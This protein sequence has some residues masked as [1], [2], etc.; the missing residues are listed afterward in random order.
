MII[1]RLEPLWTEIEEGLGV[2]AGNE[3]AWRVL[4]GEEAR[5]LS[6]GWRRE[7]GWFTIP[8]PAGFSTQSLYVTTDPGYEDPSGVTAADRERILQ[9][10]VDEVWRSEHDSWTV[11]TIPTLYR[12]ACQDVWEPDAQAMARGVDELGAVTTWLASQVGAESGWTSPGGQFA[13]GWLTDLEKHWP[14]TSQSSDTFFEFWT[15]VNDK[16]GH[17]LTMSARLTATSAQVAATVHD[18]QVNLVEATEAARDRVREAMHQWQL[19]ESDSGGWP[20]GA[21]NDNTGVRTLLNN[22]SYAAGVTGLVSTSTVLLAPVGGVA[23][24]VS[25]VSGGLT[26]LIPEQSVDMAIIRARTAADLHDAYM[27]DLRTVRDNMIAALDHVHTTPPD[28]GSNFA[29]RSLPAFVSMATGSRQ[30]WA[31]LPVTL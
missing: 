26:Y 10:A 21:M 25:V 12:M 11:G 24:W 4:G 15:D 2:L 9:D 16:L 1:D 31:P 17:Y 18:F 3:G 5:P 22:I 27:D 28:D 13:P 8:G 6:E 7:P 29:G 14:R 30:D 23:G 20:T 19:W